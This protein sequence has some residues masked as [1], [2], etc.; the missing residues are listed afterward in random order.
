MSDD[1]LVLLR[2]ALDVEM[3]K[4]KIA[5]SVGGVGEGL[6]IEYFRKTPTLPKLQSSPHGT[7]NVDALSRNGERYSIKTVCNA[8]KTST[9]Y[10][11][12]EDQKK[13]LFEYIL[14][15][16]LAKDWSLESI[17][18]L[19]WA[20][21]LKARSW[22]KRMSAWYVGIS[23]RTLGVATLIFKTPTTQQP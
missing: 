19:S 1:R 10:P 15:V 11:D 21:F 20:D 17:Y 12:K 3:R 13:Q 14:I 4:R 18:Q 6:A 8:K 7:K 16:K 23:A 2:A 9:I 5:F 22:D